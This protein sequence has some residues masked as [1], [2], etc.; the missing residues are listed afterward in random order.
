MLF[1]KKDLN[2]NSFLIFKENRIINNIRII[3]NI[4][5]LYKNINLFT[6]MVCNL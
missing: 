3:I 4:L 2:L 1:K 6:L 5:V